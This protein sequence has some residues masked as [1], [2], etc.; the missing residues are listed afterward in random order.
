MI[1]SKLLSEEEICIM[2]EGKTKPDVLLEHGR[3]ERGAAALRPY[4]NL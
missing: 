2:R 1:S 3:K 4:R